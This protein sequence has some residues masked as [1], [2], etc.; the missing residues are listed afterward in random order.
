[1]QIVDSHPDP[2][3]AAE[4]R[5]HKRAFLRLATKITFS[6]LQHADRAALMFA[7]YLREHLSPT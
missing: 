5:R 3:P 2:H 4:L 7:D 1:M 6:R